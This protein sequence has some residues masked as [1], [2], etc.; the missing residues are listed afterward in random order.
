MIIS[1]LIINFI[2][3]F[4]SFSFVELCLRVP[5]CVWIFL[6]WFCCVSCIGSGLCDELV[7]YSEESWYIAR[8]CVCNCMCDLETSRKSHSSSQFGCSTTESNIN[9]TYRHLNWSRRLLPTPWL[10]D[11]FKLCGIFCRAYFR[12]SCACR[13]QTYLHVNSWQAQ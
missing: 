2:D 5:I 11:C 1:V 12:I 6:S 10:C 8:A 4:A 13:R 3:K 7:T 9:F